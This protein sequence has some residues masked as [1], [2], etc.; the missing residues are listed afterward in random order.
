MVIAHSEPGR[1]ASGEG[2]GA[3]LPS[4]P[5]TILLWAGDDERGATW[6]DD[7]WCAF[8]GL[9]PDAARGEGW[10]NAVHPDDRAGC[11]AAWHQGLRGEAPF[12]VSYRL[13]RGDGRYRQVLDRAQPQAPAPDLGFLGT[14]V[15]ITEV[16]ERSEALRDRARQR[17]GLADLGRAALVGASFP[18]LARQAAELAASSLDVT[19]A[20]VFERVSGDRLEVSAVRG[21]APDLVGR[22]IPIDEATLVGAAVLEETPLV[23][24]DWA[25]ERRFQ[26]A[27]GTTSGVGAT[28]V[29]VLRSPSGVV[30]AIA[31]HA[32]TAHEF[33]DDEVNLLRSVANVL[34]A[35]LVRERVESERER[36][37]QSEQRVRVEL[38]AAIVHLDT[39]LE[40]APVAF[41]FCDTDFR[42]VRANA[43]LAEID[44]VS[45]AEHLGRTVA[46]VLP[47]FW[48]RIEDT[49]RHVVESGESIV[50]LELGGPA[51]ATTAPGRYFSLS[52]YPVRGGSGHVLG[53]GA[54]ALDVTER[55]R[56]ELA[57]QLV[58]EA[59]EVLV[60]APDVDSALEEAV[61]LAVPR[62]ADSCHLYYRA[63][64][65]TPHVAIAHVDADL[66]ERLYAAH[67]RWPLDLDGF[68]APVDSGRRR[69]LLLEEVT[70]EHRDQL[71][72][73]DTEHRALIDAHGVQSA[74]I[75]ALESAG[76]PVG[77]LVF[78]RTET[79]GRRFGTDDVG[80]AEALADRFAEGVHAAALRADAREAHGRVQ[81]LARVGELLTV[82]LDSDARMRR[83]VRLA[84]PAFADV[85]VAN[86]LERG[87]FHLRYYAVSPALA[88]QFPHIRDWEPMDVD[89]PSASAEAVR[90]GA[91]VLIANA[92]ELLDRFDGERRRLAHETGIRSILS[93]PLLDSDGTAMGTATFA[94]ARSGRRYSQADVPL[95]EELG[96]RAAAALRH[97]QRFEH[98]RDTAS[99]LQRSLL[100]SELPMLHDVELA[101]RYLP[102]SVGSPVGGDWYDVT[103]LPDGRLVLGIGDVVGHGLRAA[104]S[105]GRLRAALQVCAFDGDDPGR[106]LDRMNRFMLAVPDA[107]MATMIVARYDPAS[108]ALEVASAGHPPLLLVDEHG[109]RFAEPVP[110]PPL[111]ATDHAEYVTHE[112][113]LLPG[114]TVVFYTDGLVERRGESLDVGFAR[115]RTAA[116]GA[117]GDPERVA[118]ELLDQLLPSGSA[119]DDVAV[120]ILRASPVGLPLS[121]ELPAWP[122]ELANLRRALRTWLRRAEVQESVAAEIVV[123]VNEAAAN[124]VEH[125]YGLRD[126]RFGVEARREDGAVVVTVR[127]RGRWREPRPGSERGRGLAL[128]RSLMD[129]VAVDPGPTGTTVHLVRDVTAGAADDR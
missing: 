105:T 101:A 86:I 47:E 38:E 72:G 91:A 124:A 122:R 103:T 53:F 111:R 33:V 123:A 66:R 64:G 69:T 1:G 112:S 109:A 87:A 32:A 42:F 108:G 36:V 100:P 6:H 89:T 57:A 126:A 99:A 49:L 8:T 31:V 102:A 39:L 73:G 41:A 43:P 30:G 18:T 13:L 74:I 118:D 44:G 25:R 45:V 55:R 40:H 4:S 34:G 65:D 61:G 63:P 16:E 58:A 95:A 11:A 9:T 68:L 115:L 22:V 127:D 79:S 35:A 97:A 84:V 71:A 94:M 21:L 128:I 27:D 125:A 93:V 10:L 62:F 48:P 116:E 5:P 114:S 88:S 129:E 50:G 19:S 59:V 28:G 107:D 54:I 92:D 2:S 83:F 77:L 12:E 80:V 121:L 51:G 110:A 78:N 60:G 113:V 85:C 67:E 14:V 23:V 24:S 70:D 104:L 119:A 46:E 3:D 120:L 117:L 15:D 106:V 26:R 96:R 76:R 7:A 29:A 81:L 17:S 90:R 75:T 56:A 98:E 37:R 82:D 20:A 52:V